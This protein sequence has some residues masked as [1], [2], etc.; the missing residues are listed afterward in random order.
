MT[1]M[2]FSFTKGP[3]HLEIVG[4]VHGTLRRAL[5]SLLVK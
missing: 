3:F 1:E 5:W 2:F 4:Y